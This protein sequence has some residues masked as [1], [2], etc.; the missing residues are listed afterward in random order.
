MMLDGAGP[1]MSSLMKKARNSG[2]LRKEFRRRLKTATLADS[3]FISLP[4]V[5]SP[6]LENEHRSASARK[7][8]Q[9]SAWMT[10][11]PVARSVY[12]RSAPRE[13]INRR[14]RYFKSIA[15]KWPILSI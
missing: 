4:A 9:R 3:A 13:V 8:D 15:L 1:A 14:G 5:Q 12:G 2:L 10:S 7:S 6:N 11:W